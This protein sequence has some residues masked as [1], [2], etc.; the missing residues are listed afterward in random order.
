MVVSIF[1]KK[2]ETKTF[3]KSK[4]LA[5]LAGSS[6]KNGGLRA[7]NR[8]PALAWLSLVSA[9]DSAPPP[10]GGINIESLP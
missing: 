4:I 6:E 3:P 1:N 10:V 8:G 7:P 5:C 9:L 2:K